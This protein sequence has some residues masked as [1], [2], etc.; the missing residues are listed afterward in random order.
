MVLID[1]SLGALGDRQTDKISVNTHDQKTTP[2]IGYF[3]RFF[4]KQF[5]IGNIIRAIFI[6]WVTEGILEASEVAASTD[7]VCV[8]LEAS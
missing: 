2:S 5:C 8:A 7:E 3:I 1:F 4:K 6:L